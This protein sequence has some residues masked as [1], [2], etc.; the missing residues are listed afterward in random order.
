MTIR[1]SKKWNDEIFEPALS[2]W[3]KTA[4]SKVKSFVLFLLNEQRESNLEGVKKAAKL[5]TVEVPTSLFA[6]ALKSPKTRVKLRQWIVDSGI[7]VKDDSW[8]STGLSEQLHTPVRCN[9]WHITESEYSHKKTV[10]V[11]YVVG[12]NIVRMAVERI[13]DAEGLKVGEQTFTGQWAVDEFHAGSLSFSDLVKVGQVAKRAKNGPIVKVNRTYDAVAL[14]PKNL[15]SKCF[16]GIKEVFDISAA[17]TICAPLAASYLG[18]NVEFDEFKWDEWT[19]NLQNGE[20][21]DP[22]K[23]I[24]DRMDKVPGAKWTESTRKT[25]KRDLQVVLNG[26]LDVVYEMNSAYKGYEWDNYDA[27]LYH[28]R[29]MQWSVYEAVR[30]INPDLRMAADRC[31]GEKGEFFRLTTKGEKAIME[32]LVKELNARGIKA[33]R[34]HDAL[35][36]NDERLTDK[37]TARKLVGEILGRYS[38]RRLFQND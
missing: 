24:W 21:A 14:C 27:R 8:V 34:V 33:H 12:E 35:W 25:V 32:T 23:E 26:D 9:R 22:Y 37:T 1:I 36:S 10:E 13:K 20:T 7:A 29:K 4:R 28:C 19:A 16:N 30:R 17:C 31:R 11:E 15:R 18:W 3:N 38:I 5:P 6:S 2:E